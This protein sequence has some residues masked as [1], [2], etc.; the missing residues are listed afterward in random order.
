MCSKL[1]SFLVSVLLC[2]NVLLYFWATV[3]ALLCLVCPSTVVRNYDDDDDDDDEI[4]IIRKFFFT[5]ILHG[6]IS[7]AQGRT[8]RRWNLDW[9]RRRLDKEDSCGMQ[10]TSGTC[11]GNQRHRLW[12][13]VFRHDICQRK[14]TPGK[15][16]ENCPERLIHEEI[17]SVPV[18]SRLWI[19]Q[20]LLRVQ[21]G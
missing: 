1:L 2:Q 21:Y 7:T 9:W 12:S 15:L 11:G 13:S 4:D 6:R 16:G 20:T 8:R 3:S 17:I 10:H 14:A 19:L 18:S 5:S